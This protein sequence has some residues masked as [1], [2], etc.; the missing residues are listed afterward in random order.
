M[1]TPPAPVPH[2]ADAA[3]VVALRD[4]LAA[5]FVK[6][7]VTIPSFQAAR[8]AG[9]SMG[10][11]PPA[12]WGSASSPPWPLRRLMKTAD[13]DFDLPDDNIALRPA[14]PRDHARFLV[15]RP[16]ATPVLE[17]HHAQAANWM[18]PLDPVRC[19]LMLG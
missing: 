4:A 15:V 14:S 12:L 5:V 19:F 3:R 17:D 11:P 10:A 13:F 7:V 6:G 9:P 8:S 18:C 16:D 1:E 2:G